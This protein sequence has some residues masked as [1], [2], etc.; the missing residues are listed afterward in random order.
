MIYDTRLSR[1]F[2]ALNTIDL[3]DTSFRYGWLKK[4]EHKLSEEAKLYMEEVNK[5][6][7]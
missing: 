4:F 1:K 3:F 2:K 7:V 6:L 5:M